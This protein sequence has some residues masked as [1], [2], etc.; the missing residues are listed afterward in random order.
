MEYGFEKYT[1][2]NFFMQIEN[3]LDRA[4]AFV[5]EE[6]KYL[7]YQVRFGLFKKHLLDRFNLIVT[8]AKS[9]LVE[10]SYTEHTWKELHALHYA[11]T[12]YAYS[13]KVMRVHFWDYD[14]KEVQKTVG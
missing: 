2:S 5:D 10:E 14:L 13:N 12:S 4:P 11:N 9:F 1:D 7:Y 8:Q 6:E 3:I